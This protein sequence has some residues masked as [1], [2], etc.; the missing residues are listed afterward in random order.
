MSAWPHCWDAAA[1]HC[2]YCCPSMLAYV[3]ILMNIVSTRNTTYIYAAA[4]KVDIQ[5]KCSN[6]IQNVGGNINYRYAMLGSQQRDPFHMQTHPTSLREPGAA[7]IPTAMLA[8]KYKINSSCP[9][10][11][12]AP[13][14]LSC[15]PSPLPTPACSAAEPS[16]PLNPFPMLP[17]ATVCHQSWY[18]RPTLVARSQLN[19]MMARLLLPLLPLHGPRGRSNQNPK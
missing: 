3:L 9:H 19:S 12:K 17:A 15:H 1:V 2:S 6:Q 10:P 18:S 13:A 8:E 5:R 14:P 7:K 11:L 4:Q 16:E